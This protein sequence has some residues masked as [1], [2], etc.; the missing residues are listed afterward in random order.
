MKK[1]ASS[2]Q[3]GLVPLLIYNCDKSVE[4]YRQSEKFIEENGY[5]Y[6][7]FSLI[8]I[9]Q[10]ISQQFPHTDISLGSGHFFP[11]MECYEEI[12]ISSNLC[13]FGF[14]KQAMISL[15]T[16]LELGV[17][18][19][20]WNLDDNAH[21]IIKNW[22][23]SEEDTPLSKKIWKKLEG[24]S[25][26]ELLQ[27]KYDIKKEFKHLNNFLSNYVHSKGVK[28]CNSIGFRTGCQKFEEV[29]FLIWYKLL[30]RVTKVIVI[31]YL[32]KYPI[33]VIK[34][35]YSKK[36]G[37]DI[38]MFGGLEQFGVE[39]VERLIGN[40]V[41]DIIQDIA[42]VDENIQRIMGKVSTL[43][44]ITDE[45]VENQVI[46]LAKSEIELAGG[47]EVGFKNWLRMQ[48]SIYDQCKDHWSLKQKENHQRLVGHITNWAKENC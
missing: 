3:Q 35:D 32:T 26:F 2:H 4:V 20:Y 34:Y 36:F 23:N 44:N 6:K 15:R 46:R 12:K 45:D 5:E 7:L 42:K 25:N 29:G 11:W 38:P 9:Y 48:E 16:A 31:L 41:F 43:P 39:A 47:P 27:K 37:I 40:D 28:Y 8:T 18:S 13:F 19:I 1:K 17:L 10:C 22:L 24:H 33:G 21:E 14:Y 30:E